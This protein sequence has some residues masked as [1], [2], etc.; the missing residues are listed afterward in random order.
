MSQRNVELN[1][2]AG[3]FDAR[4][5]LAQDACVRACRADDQIKA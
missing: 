5:R 3:T 1:F 2:V 4:P